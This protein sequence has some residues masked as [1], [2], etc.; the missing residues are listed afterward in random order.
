MKNMSPFSII[1]VML[2]MLFFLIW[3]VGQVVWTLLETAGSRMRNLVSLLL[4]GAMLYCVCGCVSA[5][6]LQASVEQ[7]QTQVVINST[8]IIE[9]E[10]ELK[11]AHNKLD[12]AISAFNKLLTVMGR[13]IYIAPAK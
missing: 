2:S 11:T 9:L 12:E 8:R 1:V 10:N 13:N 4:I 5:G 6:S 3:H 7:S